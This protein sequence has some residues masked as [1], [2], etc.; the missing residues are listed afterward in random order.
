M[1]FINMLVVFGPTPESYVVSCGRRSSYRGIPQSLANAIQNGGLS[2]N[3]SGAHQLIPHIRSVTWNMENWVG[4]NVVTGKLCY[5]PNIEPEILKQLANAEHVSFGDANEYIVKLNDGSWYGNINNPAVLES[6]ASLRKE[7]SEFDAQLESIVIG[8]GKNHFYALTQGFLFYFDDELGRDPNHPLV[9]VIREFV[10]SGGSWRI[11]R[12]SVLCPWDSQY[13]FLN[14]QQEGSTVVQRRWNLPLEMGQK[15]QNL[16]GLSE[17]PEEQSGISCSFRRTICIDRG[18][19]SYHELRTDAAEY[20]VSEYGCE[21]KELMVVNNH[22]I[23]FVVPFLVGQ[24][25][26]ALLFHFPKLTTSVMPPHLGRTNT[27]MYIYYPWRSL[28]DLSHSCGPS[29]WSSYAHA[30]Q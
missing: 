30:V 26:C 22:S 18:Y 12:S 27:R 16:R 3:T 13:F 19:Y 7:I 1:V 15:M 17:T 5:S 24:P 6:L 25:S 21:A 4:H 14:F 10:D 29:A 28:A 11:L 23:N 8:H 2:G 9:K 20:D